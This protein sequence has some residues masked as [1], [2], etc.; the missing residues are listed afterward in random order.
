MWTAPD[1]TPLRPSLLSDASRQHYL[2]VLGE[3]GLNQVLSTT[4]WCGRGYP[5]AG[6]PQRIADRWI[7]TDVWPCCVSLTAV[8]VAPTVI[9]ATF[10]IVPVSQA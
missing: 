4:N 7:G 8:D 10:K 2:K 9:G 3:Q 5:A 1:S 6:L